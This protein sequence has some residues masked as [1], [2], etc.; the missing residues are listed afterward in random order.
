MPQPP[1]TFPWWQG[2]G[3]PSLLRT[4]HAISLGVF[5]RVAG[6]LIHRLAQMGGTTPAKAATL[7]EDPVATE[8]HILVWACSVYSAHADATTL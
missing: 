3:F 6:L 7:L 8:E 4:T 1:T 2:V 5:F